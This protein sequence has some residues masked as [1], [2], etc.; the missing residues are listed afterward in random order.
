LQSEGVAA[1]AVVPGTM[2]STVSNYNARLVQLTRM[3]EIYR[4]SD[5]KRVRESGA[6]VNLA[7]KK[8]GKQFKQVMCRLL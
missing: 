8:R 7:Q 1:Y 4:C 5:E 3:S 6:G 2:V